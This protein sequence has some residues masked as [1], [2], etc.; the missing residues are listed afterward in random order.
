M[1]NTR[2]GASRTREAVNEQSDRR[3]VEALR[4]RDAVRN[5]GPLMGD[6]VEQE[7]VGGN[8][9]GGNGDGGNGNGGNGEG[10]NG[11][12][13][14]GNGNGGN[15]NRGNGN[16]NRNGGEYGYNFRGFMPARECTYQDFLKC[17]PLNFN[18]T[19]GVVRLTRW[20]EKM[21]IVF[22][23]SNSPKKYQVK[24]QELILLCTRMVPNEEDIV[25]RFIGGLPDSI[26]GN[27]YAARSAES[28]RR[29]ESNPRDNRGQQPP[30]KRQ[31]ISGKNVVIAYTTGNNE[32]RGYTGP[33]LL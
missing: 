33:H 16:G 25:E 5:L 22:H 7:E 12:G 28:K 19:E 3:V 11:N 1:P 27:G 13:N 18:G 6:E 23:I 32:R 24:F 17:Q 30:F 8:G 14:G 4:V 26:Q 9:N 21:E 31:N 2:S 29:M 20:F 10:G 15:R